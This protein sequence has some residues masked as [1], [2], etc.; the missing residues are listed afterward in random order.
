MLSCAKAYAGCARAYM[1][2]R[3]RQHFACIADIYLICNAQ[4]ARL[5]VIGMHCSSCSTA[6]EK[7]LNGTGGVTEATVSL[8]LN[9]AEVTYDPALVTEVRKLGV[10]THAS[11]ACACRVGA[12]WVDRAS[13]LETPAELLAEMSSRL[14]TNKH[15]RLAQA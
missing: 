11:L 6:V 2:F 4:V 12:F 5:E 3:L 15:D 1:D 9:M 14:A 10:S 8:S 13:S 7:A